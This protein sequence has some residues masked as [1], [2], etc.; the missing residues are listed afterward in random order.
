MIYNYSESEKA[1][2]DRGYTNG[3]KSGQNVVQDKM[4]KVIRDRELFPMID[5]EYPH[6]YADPPTYELKKGDGIRYRV[7]YSDQT[8]PYVD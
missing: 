5:I 6:Y 7:S 4:D 3:F 2:Y 8:H 1:A